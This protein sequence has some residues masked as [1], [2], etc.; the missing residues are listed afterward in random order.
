M[1]VTDLAEVFQKQF[2]CFGEST[3]KNLTISVLLEKQ[4]KIINKKGKEITKTISYRLKFIYSTWFMGRTLSNLV[5]H[6]AGRIHKIK[7][8][9]RH[10]DKK[11]ETF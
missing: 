4:V 9:Y 10:N 6:F 5:K 8:K 7:Y 1:I 3:K 2:N 11:C